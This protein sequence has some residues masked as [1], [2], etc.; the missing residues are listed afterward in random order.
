MESITEEWNTTLTNLFAL[1]HDVNISLLKTKS[2]YCLAV[3]QAINS[4]DW[5]KELNEFV[6]KWKGVHT[7]EPMILTR[8]DLSWDGQ[9][10]CEDSLNIMTNG[11]GTDDIQSQQCGSQ[12]RTPSNL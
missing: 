9:N 7:V 1:Y 12:I 6:E 11:E 3:Q 2:Q 10:Y 4:I 5:K 8:E